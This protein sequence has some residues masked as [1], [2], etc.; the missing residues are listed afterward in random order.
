MDV[1]PFIGG[2]DISLVSHAEQANETYVYVEYTVGKRLHITVAPGKCP[3]E[4]FL[5][6]FTNFLHSLYELREV[7][8]LKYGSASP[9]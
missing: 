8:N 5:E 9:T 1:N 7:A 3:D 4:S 6:L 2:T